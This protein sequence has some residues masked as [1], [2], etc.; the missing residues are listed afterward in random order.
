MLSRLFVCRKIFAF[1]DGDSADS[2]QKFSKVERDL[3][4]AK[5]YTLFDF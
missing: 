5:G 3:M 1:V 2:L 4:K